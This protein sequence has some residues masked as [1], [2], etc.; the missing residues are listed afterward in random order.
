MNFK[1]PLI[2]TICTLL[3]V[4]VLVVA[5]FG[6]FWPKYE[7]QFFELGLLGENKTAE[8]YYPNDNSTL[9]VGSQMNWHIYLHNHMNKKYNVSIRVKVA[10]S[11]DQLP[12]DQENIPSPA[13]PITEFALSLPKNATILVP[14]SWR[15]QEVDSNSDS[16]YL[17]R[18]IINNQEILVD[19]PSSAEASFQM[20]FELWVYNQDTNEY[21]FVWQRDE[22]MAST[23]LYAGFKINST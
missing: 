4:L 13:D 23:S 15:I 19:I 1:N 14:Y 8:Y 9:Q 2:I 7:E 22:E 16:I 17:K 12:K 11:I 21:Q 10:N 5:T 18:L 3:A 20:I 6:A